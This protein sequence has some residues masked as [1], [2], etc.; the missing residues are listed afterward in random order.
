MFC[1]SFD[2][3]FSQ[4]AAKRT[5]GLFSLY[6]L[7]PWYAF[8]IVLTI[9]IIKVFSLAQYTRLC[10]RTEENMKLDKAQWGCKW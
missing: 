2:K 4:I 6:E 3:S 10:N 9:C 8:N 7:S 5:V 1:F